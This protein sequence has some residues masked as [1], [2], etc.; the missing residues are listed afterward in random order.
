MFGHETASH[1]DRSELLIA[2]FVRIRAAG[3]AGVSIALADLVERIVM[4]EEAAVALA[5]VGV[6][7]SMQDVRMPDLIHITLRAVGARRTGAF[8]QE[9][10][11]A[12]FGC[13]QPLLVPVR[14]LFGHAG[15][16]ATEIERRLCSEHR[17]LD[18]VTHLR[19]RQALG[20]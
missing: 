14:V 4:D 5:V 18:R 13:H 19:L 16:R 2:D 15:H 17:P 10:P 6:L 7:P 20:V 8:Q 12:G 11:I 3:P 9:D 1:S